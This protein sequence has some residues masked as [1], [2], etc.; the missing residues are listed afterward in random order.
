MKRGNTTMSSEELD[1]VI[2]ASTLR[3]WINTVQKI[4][5]TVLRDVKSAFVD[6]G[7]LEGN[8]LD[9]LSVVQNRAEVLER[10]AAFTQHDRG[11]LAPQSAHVAPTVGD[12]CVIG[13]ASEI[14]G[15]DAT[16]VED[17]APTRAE[18]KMLGLY[19]LD[20][21]YQER[22]CAAY[23]FSGSNE[24]RMMHFSWERFNAIE[25]AMGNRVPEFTIAL[26]V[27]QKRLTDAEQDFARNHARNNEDGDAC[28]EV[29]AS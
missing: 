18:I 2:E 1:T 11:R 21:H 4:R 5:H 7:R 8:M 13:Y 29:G 24:W 3:T 12:N 28:Q 25:T 20:R 22:I 27:W 10:T 9:R 15:G 23:G 17:F 14:N 16:L 19:Y 26:N 6:L